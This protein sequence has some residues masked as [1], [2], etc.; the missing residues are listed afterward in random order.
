LPTPESIDPRPAFS[1]KIEVGGSS[2]MDTSFQEVGGITSQ[3]ETD[4]HGEGGERGFVHSLP[5]AVKHPNLVLK[6]GLGEE[7]SPLVTWCR[8]VFEGGLSAA[9]ETKEVRVT[10]LN[11]EGEPLLAWSFANAYPVKWVIGPFNSTEN[12]VAIETV[13]LSYTYSYRVT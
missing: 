9:I 11:E 13:E 12:Q 10:L 4:A 8:E 1:F 7:A 2:G 6:R 3:I 5:K